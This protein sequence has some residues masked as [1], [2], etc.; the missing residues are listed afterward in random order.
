[1]RLRH[2]SALALI[3]ACG[4]AAA[5]S[6]PGSADPPRH[7]RSEASDCASC[8]A[9]V[10]SEW[11]ASLHRQSF[12][13]PLF[14]AGYRVDHRAFCREC[15]APRS[16]G[17][18]PRPGTAAHDE[19]ITCT[20]CHTP[21]GAHPSAQPASDFGERA[22]GSCH[23]F[24]FPRQASRAAIDASAWMQRT[25]D[26]HRESGATESCADCHMPRAGG[27]ASH[28]FNVGASH[29]AGAIAIEGELVAHPRSTEVVVRLS[30]VRAG[31][32]V[33]TG[34]VLRALEL[35]VWPASAPERIQR[36]ELTRVF[37][38]SL[39]FDPADGITARTIEREDTRIPPRGERVE[40]FAFDEETR[41]V[42]YRL[43]YLHVSRRQ[44]ALQGVGDDDNRLTVAEGV[45][46]RDTARGSAPRAPS[47]G[48]R[49]RG[50]RASP[51]APR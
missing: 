18:D 2:I 33:P 43:D 10:A 35:S 36:R 48:R 6:A 16:E 25:V 5:L 21:R 51:H 30:A 13:D 42:R 34:D 4:A 44:A 31:H 32:A 28:A 23:Q 22:C 37:G 27:R 49:A 8:H 3:A 38:T 46:T 50:P 1:M 12:S 26:E 45:L 14:Q 17:A 39:G 19:G 24:H 29:I 41:E 47:P 15:H 11:R 7:A 40:R 20:E 9:Q